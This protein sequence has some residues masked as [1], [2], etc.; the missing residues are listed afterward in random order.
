MAI[1]FN[2]KYSCEHCLHCFQEGDVGCELNLHPVNFPL[3]GN[4]CQFFDYNH[5]YEQ[6]NNIHNPKREIDTDEFLPIT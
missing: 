2:Q 1:L 4:C 6:K 3:I 5:I